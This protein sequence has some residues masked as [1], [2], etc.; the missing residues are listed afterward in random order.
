MHVAVARSTGPLPESGVDAGCSV[1][2][3]VLVASGTWHL[4]NSGRMWELLD[5]CM[6]VPAPENSMR[7]G[8]VFARIDGDI[9]SLFR[10]HSRLT[11][12]GEAGLI[13]LEWLSLSSLWSGTLQGAENTEERYQ[14]PGGKGRTCMRFGAFRLHSKLPAIGRQTA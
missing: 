6:A 7:A 2:R 11:V 4:G 8:R 13:L 12:A 1:S 5:G 10:F 3:C 9:P 14:Q